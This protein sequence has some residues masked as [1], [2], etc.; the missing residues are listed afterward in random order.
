LAFASM[1]TIRGRG[2]WELDPGS[3]AI[4]VVTVALTVGSLFLATC[5][6]SRSSPFKTDDR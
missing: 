1:Q 5:A 4:L 3:T 2:R 6:R